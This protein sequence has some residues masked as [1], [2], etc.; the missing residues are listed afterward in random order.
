MKKR[1]VILFFLLGCS[2]KKSVEV[3]NFCNQEKSQCNEKAH[4]EICSGSCVSVLIEDTHDERSLAF[5]SRIKQCDEDYK[6]CL[7]KN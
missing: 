3:V 1:I 2:D 7:N 5:T 6:V 4:Q